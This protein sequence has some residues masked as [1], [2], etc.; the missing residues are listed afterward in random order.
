[1]AGESMSPETTP[2]S[3]TPVRKW[4]NEVKKQF[5]DGKSSGTVTARVNFDIKEDPSGN[6]QI[7]PLMYEGYTGGIFRRGNISEGV[8][9]NLYNFAMDVNSRERG[10]PHD[11]DQNSLYVSVLKPDN[12]Q[13]STN[14]PRNDMIKVNGRVMQDV[15]GK[16]NSII[17][18]QYRQSDLDAYHIT[19]TK[20]V[21]LVVPDNTANNLRE[22]VRGG[23]DPNELHD[24]VAEIF[25]TPETR[26]HF[27][28]NIIDQYNRTNPNA[29][30]TKAIKTD[31]KQTFLSQTVPNQPLERR[32][33]E[34]RAASVQEKK[35]EPKVE[36]KPS[37]KEPEKTSP[38]KKETSIQNWVK[39]TKEQPTEK[40][41][42]ATIIDRSDPR[43]IKISK[44]KGDDGKGFLVP[45]TD[46]LL[47]QKD[48][49]LTQIK[50]EPNVLY[51][52]FSNTKEG[53][54]LGDRFGGK[55]K[56]MIEL[57]SSDPNQQICLVVAEDSAKKLNDLIKS[58]QVNA[59]ELYDTVVTQLLNDTNNLFTTHPDFKD[60]HPYTPPKATSTPER[61]K[62]A[63]TSEQEE[64]MKKAQEM[65]MKLTVQQD[66]LGKNKPATENY[67]KDD[68]EPTI[69]IIK[70]PTPGA[71]PSLNR[72]PFASNPDQEKNDQKKPN[73][74]VPSRQG[75]S[76]EDQEP[77]KTPTG[78]NPPSP[79]PQGPE[80]K[81][82]N[83]KAK[84]KRTWLIKD[85]T[86]MAI[87]NAMTL[88]EAKNLILSLNGEIIRGGALNSEGWHR[89]YERLLDIQSDSKTTR[90]DFDRIDLFLLNMTPGIEAI[91]RAAEV[92]KVKSEPG[93]TSNPAA[94]EHR[95]QVEAPNPY[96]KAVFRQGTWGDHEDAWKNKVT[97][98]DITN[99]DER[100][101]WCLENLSVFQRGLLPDIN[102][103]EDK[104]IR[105]DFDPASDAAKKR[106]RNPDK[107]EGDLK[108]TEALLN[109]M[110]AVSV[111]R[112][113]ME[114][115]GGAGEAYATFVTFGK[116][117]DNQELVK[118]YL[119]AGDPEKYNKIIT[120]KRIKKYYDTIIQDANITNL[121]EW[122]AKNNTP[123][124]FRV[125]P[126]TA[127]NGRLVDKL[128]DKG[129]R[130]A[131]LKI[132]LNGSSD[133]AEKMA[134]SLAYDAFIVDKYTRWND[135]LL[136]QDGEIKLK[137]TSNWSD[138]PFRAI[139]KPSNLP[140]SKKTYQSNEGQR[141]LDLI[142][143]GFAA[144]DCFVG[145]L[146]KYALPAS[147]VGK[148]GN[149][150]KYSK[151]LTAAIGNSMGDDLP[152]FDKDNAKLNTIANNFIQLFANEINKDFSGD[153]DPLRQKLGTQIAS[154]MFA[155]VLDAKAMAAVLESAPP[156]SIEKLR[157]HL[158]SG[159]DKSHRKALTP[160][161][162]A[163]WG[164]GGYGG[165]GLIES[166]KGGQTGM[167]FR[168]NVNFIYRDIPISEGHN[169]H[170]IKL[171]R[172]A[173]T[174]TKNGEKYYRIRAA[175]YM[176]RAKSLLT[177]NDQINPYS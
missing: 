8:G 42:F 35:P 41:P 161:R 14:S 143:T 86:D 37:P 144:P 95:G 18:F 148:L 40:K 103:I 102:A 168:D 3:E 94:S 49:E 133:P 88:D 110:I 117:P 108:E 174:I 58:K 27:D 61:P 57:S 48:L 169:N 129:G 12:L 128:K 84:F 104:W 31:F 150:D 52:Q 163:I 99:S 130:D 167:L 106:A 131:Y 135:E 145:P 78:E 170:G 73:F 6:Q 87:L 34:P 111:A 116:G 176:F 11:I 17:E 122:D 21:Y 59:N 139:L 79:N 10:F 81:G 62:S 166:L 153:P 15:I 113:A 2:Q 25:T 19:G 45:D 50:K 16:G 132:I 120:N 173:P 65:L 98:Y 9:K 72:K 154:W 71:R 76:G 69:N 66:I 70:P 162:D 32:Q 177:T 119:L 101:R 159:A 26:D 44:Q 80:N 123:S 51:V 13:F 7:T 33:V 5:R 90:V 115:S 54:R 149:F 175:D 138:D 151:A 155:Q 164:P 77:P 141:I 136:K 114:L 112:R 68:E 63:Q 85:E 23:I 124:S 118:N 160:I 126:K 67:D 100:E 105:Q 91:D 24:A 74:D 53:T 156:S 20:W 146:A 82:G 1:M 140:R 46:I 43:D 96:V 137:P 171:Y 125:D 92:A 157:E 89:K 165:S 109:A 4:A 55:G 64:I 30:K 60:I 22:M 36:A 127:L 172:D 39:E 93:K 142:D 147:A 29:I 107:L 152:T 75:G 38:P 28:A 56:T 97:F 83:E 47:L 121:T 158:P 134:A